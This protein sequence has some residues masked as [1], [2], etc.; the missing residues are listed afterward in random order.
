MHLNLSTHKKAM[1]VASLL[2]FV[3]TSFALVIPIGKHADTNATVPTEVLADTD[4]PDPNIDLTNVDNLG[5]LLVG[6]GGAGHDGGYLTDANQLLYVDFQQ[7]KIALIALPR[8]LLV[9]TEKGEMKL[10]AVAFSDSGKN[11]FLQNGAPQLKK[12]ISQITGL[13]VAYVIGIDFV[14]F[15]RL[16][17]QDL[18]GIEVDVYET[19]DDPWYP[20]K[21]EELNL[22]KMTP[23]EITE[24]HQKYSGFELERQF[25]C[26][27]KRL[28]FDPGLNKME[29]GD[30]L[31]YV[32]SRH[33]SGEG[34]I[35]RGKRQQEVLQ[36]VANKIISLELIDQLPDLFTKAKNNIYTDI[37][38]DIVK[39]LAP[40]AKASFDFKKI[41]INL[42][43]TNVLAISSSSRFGSIIIPKAGMHDWG[44]GQQFIQQEMSKWALKLL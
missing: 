4:Q 17:G 15:Q 42:S 1:L 2:S 27:Y 11:E 9:K 26:R 39:Y 13:N 33:G 21:G 20:I 10:N 38:L 30:A 22:C 3:A 6:F 19:L 44:G 34:D 32:R 43:T 14:G 40:L 16:I 31:E 35:S 8:D 25:T 23:E 37:D 7:K 24:V 12:A 41:T 5:I 18:G 36:A 28:H 29:G